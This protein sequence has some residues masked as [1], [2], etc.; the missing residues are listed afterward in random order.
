MSTTTLPPPEVIAALRE[1]DSATISNA[2]E[3]FRVRD[4]TAA[5][6]SRELVCQFPDYKPM[7]GYALTCTADTTTTGDKRPMRLHAMFDLMTQSPK[8]IVIVVQYVGPDRLRS[9]LSGD[10]FALTAQKL[11]AA[12]LV[13]DCGNRDKEGIRRN[14]PGYQVFCPG[15]V[16]SH[17]YGV[18][19]DYGITVSVGGLT[20]RQ[21]DLLH[22][23]AN[24]LVQVPLE[25]VDRLVGQAKATLTEEA[26]I[27]EYLKGPHVDLEGIKR[28]IGR[29]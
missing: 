18:Y 29:D 14:A 12:G 26:Q 27:L 23:D 6:A 24:G 9:C 8:P 25:I 2:I 5:Y 13:T 19:M 1:F 16:V 22:G 7:V 20:V 17:G 10:L 11:G 3:H 15:W 4:Q 28:R 21:G